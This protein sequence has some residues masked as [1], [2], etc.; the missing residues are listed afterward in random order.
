[1]RMKEKLV[2]FA[3]VPLMVW[4]SGC[5]SPKGEIK[6]QGTST[7]S[8]E[9][10]ENVLRIV[11]DYYGFVKDTN[12][13]F[14]GARTEGYRGDGIT[15]EVTFLDP[16]AIDPDKR[17]I[18]IKEL[19]VPWFKVGVDEPRFPMDG[20]EPGIYGYRIRAKKDNEWPK[21]AEEERTSKK[22][23]KVERKFRFEPIKK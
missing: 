8:K 11:E 3:L 5:R 19:G 12:T 16:E 15:L 6:D 21:N 14:I 7:I 17:E 10:D 22:Y 20:Y 1:M 9:V 4:A 23:A 18:R 2:S 13:L